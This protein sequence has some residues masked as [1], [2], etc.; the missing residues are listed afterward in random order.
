MGG[1]VSIAIAQIDQTVGDLEG[2]RARIIAAAERAAALGADLV[3]TPE[4]SLVGYPPEDLVLKNAFIEGARA[5]LD[6]LLAWSG[7]RAPA[8]V[9]GLPWAEEG[10]LYNAA[11]VVERGRIAARVFKRMLPNYGVFDEKRHFTP[12]ATAEPVVF[13]D[14]PLGL[15]ICEDMWFPDVPG[16][17]K[18]KGAAILIAV[19]AS[20]FE[21]EKH[22]H[23]LDVARARVAETGLALVFANQIGGQDELL[24]DGASFVLDATGQAAARLAAFAEDLAMIEVDGGRAPARIRIRHGGDAH[25]EEGEAAIYLA[26]V[27]GIRDY[28]R[29][30][31]FRQ[32]VLGLSG[33]IDSALVAALAADALGPDQVWGVMLPSPYTSRESLEDAAAVAR[34]LGIRHDVIPI[35]PA[36]EAVEEMLRPVFHG[37]APDETEENIQARLRGLVVMALSNKFGHLVL[38]TG[39]KSE[40]SVGYAT[41]YG[42]MAG[43]FSPLKDVYKTL[44]YRLARWRNAHHPTGALGPKGVVI[45][46]RILTRAPS[47]ELRPGQ[48]DQDKLPPYPVLDDILHGLIEE[49]LGF[50]DIVARGH[51][52]ELVARVEAMLYAA[53]YKRRQGAPG[54]K[55][56]RKSFTRDRRYPVTNAFRTARLRMVERKN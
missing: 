53:E 4:L 45:P 56:T 31:G 14:L 50:A 47:A 30:N 36:M 2:N 27:L 8:L 17:L 26:L 18:A 15:M 41:L 46:E 55:I 7:E 21:T 43:G 6:S 5:M 33:G 39:N 1:T 19:N 51:P 40:L 11:V 35:T 22:A 25:W 3:I 32:A 48:T 9:V 42:D 44:V 37:L 34:N 20:P 10:R 16:E 52:P 38:S 49:E 54:I 24:F 28:A 12:A 23:R 13:R 29:K